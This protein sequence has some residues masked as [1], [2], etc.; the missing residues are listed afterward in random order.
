MGENVHQSPEVAINCLHGFSKCSVNDGH[1]C[2]SVH[3]VKGKGPNSFLAETEKVA[4]T[5]ETLL[6]QSIV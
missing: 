3:T 4:Q 2:A 6:T 1:M 5:L